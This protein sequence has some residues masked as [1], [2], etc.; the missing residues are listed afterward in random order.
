MSCRNLLIECL[1]FAIEVKKVTGRIG[2]KRDLGVFISVKRLKMEYEDKKY[3]VRKLMQ[4][5]LTE[6]ERT[7]LQA[8][9]QVTRKMEH[10][11]G[12]TVRM[13][14]LSGRIYAGRFGRMAKGGKLRFIRYIVWSPL[15]YWYWGWPEPLISRCRARRMSR[16]M[17]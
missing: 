2:G 15:S 6:E 11:W 5:T 1:S 9:R 12:A 8:S 7:A 4:D 10:Q 17:S 13:S 16:C 14:P 3:I